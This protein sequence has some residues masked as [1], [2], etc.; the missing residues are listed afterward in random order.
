MTTIRDP[1]CGM[2]FLE[3]Q[4]AVTRVHQ[5]RTYGFCCAHCGGAFAADPERFVGGDADPDDAWRPASG[6]DA[7]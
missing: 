2:Q 4:C 3:E 1:V 7:P 5:G 6:P